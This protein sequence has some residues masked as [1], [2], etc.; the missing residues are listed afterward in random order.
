[1]GVLMAGGSFSGGIPMMD[2]ERLIRQT[3]EADTTLIMASGDGLDKAKKIATAV[4]LDSSRIF[5]V[6][7]ETMF[8]ENASESDVAAIGYRHWRELLTTSGEGF[9]WTPFAGP[10]DL[11]VIIYTSGSEGPAKGIKVSHFNLVSGAAQFI[12]QDKKDPLSP[13]NGHPMTWVMWL[14]LFH[15]V[16]LSQSCMIL[17]KRGAKYYIMKGLA[18]E[19]LLRNCERFKAT[20]M[21]LI[22]PIM[23][24][25]MNDPALKKYDLSSVRLGMT[26][27]PLRASLSEQFKA[28]MPNK[29]FIV[30][31]GYGMTE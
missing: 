15:A 2:T 20:V 26:G 12:E 25:I 28:A 10:T 9:D 31:Q 18:I 1:M 21:V 4:G 13:E 11:A 8:S 19:P 29:S 3:I 6:D 7:P 22:P 27:G 16:G 30:W 5:L 14:P 17:P 23:I 24:T